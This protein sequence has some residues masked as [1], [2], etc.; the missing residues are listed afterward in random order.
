MK[1]CLFLRMEAVEGINILYK[2]HQL[3]GTGIL[4]GGSHGANATE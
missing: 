2:R 3:L 4:L 1:V